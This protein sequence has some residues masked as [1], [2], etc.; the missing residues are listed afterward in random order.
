MAIYSPADLAALLKVKESTVRKYS[1]LLE[2]VGYEFQRN[3]QGQ[4]WYRDEDVIALQKFV[5]LKRNGDMTLKDCAEGVLAWSKGSD[6]TEVRTVTYNADERYNSVI[7]PAIQEEVQSLRELLEKQHE[8]ITGLQ[9]E[10]SAERERQEQKDQALFRAIE[11]LQET[12]D[13]EREQTENVLPEPDFTS[14]PETKT[15][16]KR[17]FFSRFFNKKKS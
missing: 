16:E 17:S 11:Q 15:E 1:L 14:P 7:T 6:I 10:L 8:T 3:A 9:Q 12:L 13:K 2:E 5:T 4:R